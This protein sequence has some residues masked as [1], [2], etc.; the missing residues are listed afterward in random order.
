MHVQGKL[1]IKNL[2]KVALECLDILVFNTDK[3]AE[4]QSFASLATQKRRHQSFKLIFTRHAAQVSAC[5]NPEPTRC[6][7]LLTEAAD[8]EKG[9]V[10]LK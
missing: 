6:I 2:M 7:C 10:R 1:R 9:G 4:F 8:P 3:H 5:V